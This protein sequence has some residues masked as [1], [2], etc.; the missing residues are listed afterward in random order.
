MRNF[1]ESEIEL[2]DISGKS[3]MGGF[4]VDV[5]AGYY[6][7]KMDHFRPVGLIVTGF[8]QE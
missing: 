4:E 5:Q 3:G 1:L 2:N 7:L 8:Q 6:I